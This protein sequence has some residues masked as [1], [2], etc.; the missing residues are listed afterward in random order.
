M[1]EVILVSR[2]DRLGDLVLS[3]PALGY[4]R[5]AGFARVWLHTSAYARAVGEWAKHNGIIEGVWAQGEAAPP[6]LLGIAPKELRGLSLFHA[7]EAVLA[8]RTLG[9]RQCLGPRTRLDAL[10]SYTRSVAQ[11]RSRV[12]KSEMAYNVDLARAFVSE[13]GRAPPEFRGLPALRVPETWR[14]PRQPAELLIVA[15]NGGSAHNWPMSRY[16]EVARQAVERDKKSVQFLIHGTDAEERLREF[17][18]SDLASSVEVLP[19][20]AK[21]EELIAH[22]ASC[23]EIFSSST[24]PLHI[25]HAAGRP[26]TGLYPSQPLVQSFKRWRPDG[27]WHA[28][29]VRWIHL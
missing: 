18:A 19:S 14:S 23:G 5:D 13:S 15:A 27:Y 17:R 8:F 2:C 12:A 29:P 10:W 9:I 16:L 4:L 22:I 3:L 1:S 11:H 28:A 6:E 26:V 25:A 24:G 20:F 7:P 21:L